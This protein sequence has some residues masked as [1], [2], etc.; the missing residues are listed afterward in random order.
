MSRASF[1]VPV[2]TK[3]VAGGIEV[4][5]VGLDGL[6]ASRRAGTKHRAEELLREDLRK[7]V[8]N[9]AVAGLGR[10]A[11]KRG[12][13]LDR[14]RLELTLKDATRRKVSGLFP[15]VVEPRDAGGGRLFFACYHPARPEDWF[16]SPTAEDVPERASAV[17]AKAWA[18]VEDD[19][20]ERLKS[21]G[22]DTLRMLAFVAKPKTLL[23]ELKAKKGP[24]DD[25][26]ADPLG[27]QKKKRGG[28]MRV[29]R[30]L[31]T[32]LT[33]K[34]SSAP[35]GLGL[36]RSPWRE[37]LQVL[38]GAKPK[39]SVLLVGPSGAGKSTLLRRLFADML[40]SDGYR[41]H[42]NLDKVTHVWEVSGK[43]IIAG[44]SHVGEW[45]QRCVQL[46]E[47]VR[48][49]DVVLTIPDV[50]L[51]GR[52]GQARDSERALADF[53]RGPLARGELTIAAECTEA[54][55][56][57][58]EDDAPAFASLFTKLHV[59]PAS[60]A[61]SF[62]MMLT[63]ARELEGGG[64]RSLAPVAFETV[65]ELGEAVYAAR[66]LPG[67]AVDLL[68]RLATGRSTK[69]SES[70]IEPLEVVR[71]V[72]K[73]T[74][75]PTVLLAGD[76]E[77]PVEKVAVELGRSVM[78][79]PEAVREMADL[80][81]RIKAGVCDP[82]R[83]YGV[84]LFTGPTG[85]G[86][87]ELAKALAGYLYGSPKRL[88][89]FDMSELATPDAVARL[90]GDVYAPE[91]MLTKA[92]L[93]QPFS[94]VLLDEIEK[95]HPSVLN[96][97]LQL[98]DDGRLTDASGRTASFQRAVFVM[99]SNLGARSRPPLG[100]DEAPAAIMQ[101]VARAVRDFFPPELW[102]RIDAI[103]PFSPLTLDVAISVTKKELGKMFGR[104]GFADRNIFVRAS[105]KTIESIAKDALRAEDGAR[106]LKRFLEDRVCTHLAEAIARNPAA[107]LQVMSIDRR[108]G[109]LVVDAEPL[110]E[111]EPVA[112]RYAL[113][114][115]WTAPLERLLEEVPAALATLAELATSDA[116]EVVSA[117]LRRL[118]SEHN[119]GRTEHGEP[120]YNLEWVRVT[121]AN[122]RARL[123][124]V[125][126]RSRDAHG[127]ALERALD[128]EG[129]DRG[130]SMLGRGA[131]WVV[132]AA[133]AET[134]LLARA[135]A[136]ANEPEEHAV[137]LR[138][139]PSEDE[140]MLLAWLAMT[141]AAARGEVDE[142]AWVP[143]G[144]TSAP[145]TA[146]GRAAI[147]EA[148]A[149]FPSV[150]VMKIVGLGVRD[151]FAGE[152]GMH[153]WHTL[154]S[155]PELVRVEV[156]PARART[157]ARGPAEDW[158]AARTRGERPPP[159]LPIVRTIRFDPPDQSAPPVEMEIDDYTTGYVGTQRVREIRE[160]LLPLLL[161]RASRS[162]EGSAT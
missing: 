15:L 159:L 60:R 32:D 114:T 83:P 107:A 40:E 44:M 156:L 127:E 3:K 37:Q 99:T 123:D 43:R 45:E 50:F 137:L 26:D 95:A 19:E 126:A 4:S 61:E 143:R 154:A 111:A 97:L 58:L 158:A 38:L 103:V 35:S 33:V 113:E 101:D 118:L 130:R 76:A 98:F 46:L 72:A 62:R 81:V 54:Q 134:Q 86:K 30:D 110:V 96:L 100:F 85:T 8:E 41:V 36:P 31:G 151:Y 59:S 9:E 23:G 152:H 74:G 109:E 80:V 87:T 20:L 21:N 122:L 116:L 136:R 102:N 14:V 24:F 47:D 25:L 105:E 115:L 53:F 147:G 42:R 150:L 125:L 63:R 138:F 108:D 120:L 153:V 6:T 128:R 132:L 27:H 78:G 129:R 55:L 69:G 1:T 66:A 51:F 34:A 144:E 52:I 148:L 17:F 56:R 68:E 104:Q 139:V 67:R 57:R 88:V 64:A 13:R 79:Q 75:L 149:T 160:A 161:L 106:S 146:F 121:I 39:R 5:V 77:L 73:D 90:I 16:P 94:V 22:T 131:R 12:T 48:E 93:A 10:F 135:V 18:T 65:L 89:R 124:D 119:A 142:I 145:R 140:S 112:S 117:E 84:Y 141:Y 29:L 91:G 2:Y 82:K 157:A 11:L 70:E 71:H 155:A 28:G 7:L 162:G 92:G 49:N 133:L